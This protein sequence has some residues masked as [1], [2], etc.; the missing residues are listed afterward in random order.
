MISLRAAGSRSGFDLRVS[1]VGGLGTR[2]IISGRLSRE[3]QSLLDKRVIA[4]K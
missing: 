4:L 1:A 3:I 2:K